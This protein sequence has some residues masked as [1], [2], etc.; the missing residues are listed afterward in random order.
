MLEEGAGEA[1]VGSD[2]KVDADIAF[3]L[4]FDVT[5]LRHRRHRFGG[6]PPTALRPDPVD[7]PEILDDADQEALCARH[8]R[9]RQASAASLRCLEAGQAAVAALGA[10]AGAPLEADGLATKVWVTQAELRVP[11]GERLHAASMSMADAMEE[12]AGRTEELGIEFG[13]C[14]PASMDFAMS[15][16]IDAEADVAQHRA[17]SL[18]EKALRE[19]SCNGD[20]ASVQRKVMQLAALAKCWHSVRGAASQGLGNRAETWD[21]LWWSSARLHKNSVTVVN[22]SYEVL[23]V[24]EA[25][26]GRELGSAAGAAPVSKKKRRGLGGRGGGSSQEGISW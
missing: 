20:R 15:D 12:L 13:A 17:E 4:K 19:I 21:E 18:A 6:L 25:M 7:G 26:M 23:R 3:V 10:V 16:K 2:D 22:V 5:T 1:E 14:L 8:M 9:L 11:C 24:V